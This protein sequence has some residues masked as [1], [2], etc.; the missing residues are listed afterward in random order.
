MNKIYL[1]VEEGVI[2]K[3][4]LTTDKQLAYEVRKQAFDNLYNKDGTPSLEAIEFCK[5]MDPFSNYVIHEF[6]YSAE[7]TYETIS[8]VS[9]HSSEQVLCATLAKLSKNSQTG[10]TGGKQLVLDVY[11]KYLQE[12]KV[13]ITN[14]ILDVLAKLTSIKMKPEFVFSLRD[15]DK[16]TTVLEKQYMH[17]LTSKCREDM[18]NKTDDLRKEII[19]RNAELLASTGLLA[20]RFSEESITS[21]CINNFKQSVATNLVFKDPN[22]AMEFMSSMVKEDPKSNVRTTSSNNPN[23]LRV[24]IISDM[25]NHSVKS[26][27]LFVYGQDKTYKLHLDIR[28]IHEVYF[29]T[30]ASG[31]ISVKEILDSSSQ[32]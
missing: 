27:T 20:F 28:D 3:G 24:V 17:T 30:R 7:D 2:R 14:T 21:A 16:A 8:E 19:D 15:H 12:R 23:L 5:S 22:K 9:K 29:Q 13:F 32:R 6:D 25:L 18:N 31:L 4:F 10:A 26:N 1:V 11:E